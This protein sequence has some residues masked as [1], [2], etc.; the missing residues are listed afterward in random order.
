[1][2]STPSNG[3]NPALIQGITMGVALG[4]IL[5]ILNLVGMVGALGGLFLIISII[6]ALAAYFYAGMRTS[7][8]TETIG[9]GA[10]AGLLTALIGSLFYSAYFL[11]LIFVNMASLLSNAEKAAGQSGSTVHIT[12]GV[13]IGGAVFYLV[14][15]IILSILVGLGLGALGGAVGRA[16]AVHPAAEEYRESLFQPAPAQGQPYQS[17]QPFQQPAPEGQPS[18]PPPPPPVAPDEP[19]AIPPSGV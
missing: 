6:A 13:I 9:S 4:I 17:Y 1:M 2:R 10:L 8:I 5:V 14:L 16:R 11:I 15:V 7:Q 12:S 18:P 19:P 3:R